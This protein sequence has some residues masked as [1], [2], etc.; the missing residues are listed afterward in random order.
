MV[1]NLSSCEKKVNISK[2]IVYVNC[3][4]KKDLIHGRPPQLRTQLPRLLLES[5]TLRGHSKGRGG[6]GRVLTKDR[7][8]ISSLKEGVGPI[9]PQG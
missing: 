4:E 1:C 8:W 5:S 9:T 3:G 6:G 2:L 7:F